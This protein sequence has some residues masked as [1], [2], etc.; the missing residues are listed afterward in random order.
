MTFTVIFSAFWWDFTWHGA[1]ALF[2]GR[3]LCL[4]V[5]RAH[6]QQQGEDDTQQASS[7][8]LSIESMQHEF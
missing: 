2:A 7:F 6:Q 8:T 1:K 3:G 4:Q 5:F